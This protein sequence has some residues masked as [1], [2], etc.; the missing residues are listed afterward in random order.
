MCGIL[1][2]TRPAPAEELKQELIKASARL[3]HRGPDDEGLWVRNDLGLAH[4][5][6]AVFDLSSRVRQPFS[7]L[8]HHLVFNGA[9]YNFPEIREQLR[10]Y[11]YHFRTAS[12]TEVLLAAYDHWGEGCVHQFNGMWAFAIFDEQKKQL[13]CSRDRLGIRPFYY[14]YQPGFFAFASET[15]ALTAVSSVPKTLNPDLIYEFLAYGW[16]HHTEQTFYQAIRQLPPGH[17]AIYCLSKKELTL[18]TYYSLADQVSSPTNL[19][20]AFDL[21]AEKFRSLLEDSVR[22][23]LRA[24]VPIALSVSG[25]V[26]SSAI[27]ALIQHKKAGYFSTSFPGQSIDESPFVRALADHQRIKVHFHTP[28]FSSLMQDL[29]VVC[30]QMDEPINS[31][32]VIAHNQLM[33][34]VRKKGYKVILSGQGADEILAGYDKFFLP[35]IK[36][37]MKTNSWRLA[38]EILGILQR[39]QIDWRRLWRRYHPSFRATPGTDLFVTPES[40]QKTKRMQEKDMIQCSLSLLTQIGLPERLFYEDHSNM[41]HSLE[42]RVPFLD[43]RLVAYCLNLPAG[44]K[45]HLGQRKYILRQA[46]RRDLPSTILKR[47][48]KQGYPT[49]QVQWMDEHQSLFLQRLRQAIKKRPE[50]LRKE[51]APRA[52]QVFSKKK[53]LQ[54]S[55]FWRIIAFDSWMDTLKCSD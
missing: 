13:F 17:N 38:P 46:M 14:C 42:G 37:L 31:M 43:H 26:D 36:E 18:F 8:H 27:A 25:G 15:K 4:R 3:I 51:I 32:A 6:L 41:S 52:E 19:P 35:W 50:F 47:F 48:Q 39:G 22:L 29:R 2:I 54:Y 49:P 55:L 40:Y 1:G 21:R 45:L 53:H 28:T 30:R 33:R 10:R 24:D 20:G 44:D 34:E 11:G 7:Y 5:R 23:R 16:Q 12:D 9:I